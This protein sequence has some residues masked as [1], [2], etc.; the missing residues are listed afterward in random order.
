MILNV[1]QNFK[2]WK[3]KTFSRPLKS[4]IFEEDFLF[5]IFLKKH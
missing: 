5:N 1:H 3:N 4:M 2:S